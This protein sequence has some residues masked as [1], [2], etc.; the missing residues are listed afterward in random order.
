MQFCHKQVNYLS[1]IFTR[2]QIKTSW[3]IPSMLHEATS[4]W[5]QRTSSLWHN[6]NK[7]TASS[8][9]LY[10]CHIFKEYIHLK[11]LNC[12]HFNKGSPTGLHQFANEET[13][14]EPESL[15]WRSVVHTLSY[16]HPGW[17]AVCVDGWL[18]LWRWC[19]PEMDIWIHE[20]GKGYLG[21][22]SKP[23]RLHHYKSSRLNLVK[24]VKCFY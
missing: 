23:T 9:H 13:R 11:K 7:R 4:R 21:L 8:W 16:Y 10:S 14:L 2:F 3:L 24:L 1:E 5:Q 17:T 19:L 22:C 6:E 18:L 20:T 12:W 15:H